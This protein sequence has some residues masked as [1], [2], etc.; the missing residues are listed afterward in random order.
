MKKLY[1]FEFENRKFVKNGEIANLSKLMILIT[2]LEL[3]KRKQTPLTNTIV[4]FN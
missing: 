2:E 4:I 1:D 3:I